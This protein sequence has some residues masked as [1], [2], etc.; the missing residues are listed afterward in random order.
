MEDRPPD[1]PQPAAVPIIPWEE[2]GRPWPS[3]M[4]E[5]LKLLFTQP[6]VAFERMPINQDVLRPFLFAIII[7]WLGIIFSSLWQA[8]MSG[9]MHGM[10][11]GGADY[12]RF[13]LPAL[14]LPF[15]ATFAPLI[16]VCV[17]LLSTA[18]Y[19]LFLMAV[20]GAKHGLVATLRAL[21]YAQGAQILLILPGCGGFLAGIAQIVLTI[22]G[23]SAA[24]RI[25]TGRAATAV[26][27]PTVLCCGCLLLIMVFAGAAVMS[28]FGGVPSHPSHP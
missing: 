8:T 23:L 20:G 13:Q 27:L 12:E 24:H 14:W 21:C 6:R 28:R 11:P 18:I 2:P 7:G 16:I 5:T 4:V 10:M 22:I 1:A 19:H 17:L 9:L 15:V 3:G 25:S 26:L